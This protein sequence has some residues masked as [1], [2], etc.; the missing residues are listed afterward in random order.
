MA[1]AASVAVEAVVVEGAAA[2]EVEAA[3]VEA[4]GPVTVRPGAR[5][6]ATA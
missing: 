3:E 6:S 2:A 5:G 1:S 4:A